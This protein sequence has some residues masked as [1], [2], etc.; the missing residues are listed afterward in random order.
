M[1]GLPAVKRSMR[2]TGGAS[3]G[4]AAKSRAASTPSPGATSGDHVGPKGEIERWGAKKIIDCS[5]VVGLAGGKQK[6]D[7][8]VG[9]NTSTTIVV[10]SEVR[11]LGQL[12]G[13]PR[14]GKILSCEI[15]RSK[16]GR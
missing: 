14:F 13:L 12:E 9:S 2:R 10:R 3:G 7:W 1:P 16:A 4:T 6:C 5:E 15:V 8:Y 11:R